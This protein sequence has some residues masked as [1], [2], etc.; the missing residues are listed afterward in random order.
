[1][2][3]QNDFIKEFITKL[4]F[5]LEILIEVQKLLENVDSDLKLEKSS[6]VINRLQP[7]K[8]TSSSYSG[9]RKRQT[10]TSMRLYPMNF[11]IK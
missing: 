10:T 11:L 1:M 8:T 5:D 7:L 4:E 6:N 2:G 3:N 9:N